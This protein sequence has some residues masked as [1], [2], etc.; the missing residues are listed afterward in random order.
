MYPVR[1]ELL[2]T[3]S[4]SWTYLCDYCRI[5][6]LQRGADLRGPGLMMEFRLDR[7]IFG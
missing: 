5:Q 1:L 4:Q 6:K 7:L 2:A 3:A